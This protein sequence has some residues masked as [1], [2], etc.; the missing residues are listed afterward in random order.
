MGAGVMAAAIIAASMSTMD[1]IGLTVGSSVAYDV[2]GKKDVKS[3]R[4]ISSIVMIAVLGI[5]IGM[6]NIPS[7]LSSTLTSVFMLGWS[8]TGIAFIPPVLSMVMNRGTRRSVLA[9]SLVGIVVVL[10]YG[11]AGLIGISLPLSHLSF[12]LSLIISTAI[13]LTPRGAARENNG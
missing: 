8:I 3:V 10:L 9:G 6:F 11:T 2:L 5:V 7:T 1:S 4:L 13:T 12:T